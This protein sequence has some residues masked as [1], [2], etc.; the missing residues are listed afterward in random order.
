MCNTSI[1][2]QLSIFCLMQKQTNK[3]TNKQNRKKPT[4]LISQDNFILS[5]ISPN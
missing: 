2:T 4:G 1:P 5:R 3:Q